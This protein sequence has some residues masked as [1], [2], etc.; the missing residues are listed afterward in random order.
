MAG[1]PGKS[2]DPYPDPH[3]QTQI[4]GPELCGIRLTQ[5]RRL[6]DRPAKQRLRRRN[7]TLQ[8]AADAAGPL[9]R[10]QVGLSQNRRGGVILLAPGLQFLRGLPPAWKRLL[11]RKMAYETDAHELISRAQAVLIVS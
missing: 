5:K 8:V 9:D 10:A 6:L 7:G 4:T 1:G 2:K 3:R 11:Y